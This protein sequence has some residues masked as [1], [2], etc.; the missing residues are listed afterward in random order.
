MTTAFGLADCNNFYASCERVFR[1]RLEGRPVVVVGNNDGC[2]IARSNEAK[3]L[4]IPMGAPLHT[5]RD[6]LR[7]HAVTVFSANF[8]LYGDLSQRVMQVLG[9]FAP[10]LE[11]YSIDEAF[12]DLGA[13]PPADR[14]RFA[15]H[16]RATVR[17]QTG[18]PVSIGIAPTK[19]LAKL[20]NDRAKHLPAGVLDLP[21]AAAAVDLLRA[22]DV[23]DVWG[24]GPRRAATLRRHGIQTADDLRQ[25]DLGWVRQ[26]LSVVVARTVLELRGISCLPLEEVYAPKQEICTSRAFGQPVR[27]LAEAQAA[28]S[29]YATRAAEKLRRQHSVAGLVT[30]FLHTNP[31]RERDPQ[32]SAHCAMPIVPTDDTLAI[33]AAARSGIARCFRDGYAYHKCGVV[34]S[35]ITP[36]AVTQATLF[37]DLAPPQRQELMTVVDAINHKWGRDTIRPAASGFR[38]P[39]AMKQA[40][41]SPR[42]TTRWDELP[43]IGE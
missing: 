38:R 31:F 19:T 5:I 15:G 20:A 16:L 43:G 10:T 35:H 23:A 25:A 12:L 21:D 9:T 24:I 18:I 41:R 33:V 42:Y 29:A 40:H 8:A 22:T 7:Q 2:V 6:V 36:D 37:P 13:V 30:V 39:W 4:G 32:W 3:A 34:L 14:A 11:T 26:S 27:H 1:P 17:R 28:A